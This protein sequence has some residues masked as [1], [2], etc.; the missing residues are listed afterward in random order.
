MD[1]SEINE[2][3]MANKVFAV[4]RLNQGDDVLKIIDAARV[5]GVK[6]IE[7]TLTTPNAFEI[8]P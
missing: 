7:L 8:L 4:V 3:L 6:N 5:G 1:R 2:K